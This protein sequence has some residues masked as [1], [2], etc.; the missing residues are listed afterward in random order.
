M[1]EGIRLIRIKYNNKIFDVFSDIGHNKKFLEV[2]TKDGKELFYHPDLKDLINLNLIYNTYS[3]KKYIKKKYKFKKD[4]I[5]NLKINYNNIKKI[6]NYL[7][8][9]TKVALCVTISSFLFKGK[10]DDSLPE[11]FLGAVEIKNDIEFDEYDINNVSFDEIKETL[12]NNDSIDNKYKSMIYQYISLLEE[13]LPDIDLRILNYNLKDMKVVLCPGKTLKDESAA[14]SYDANN[15]I[16]EI[17]VGYDDYTIKNILF[18]ELT[19]AMT[20]FNQTI[21]IINEKKITSQRVFKQY[22]TMNYYGESI[23]EGMTEVLANFL[24]SDCSTLAEYYKSE[25]VTFLG[26]NAT[27]APTCYKLLKL[28]QDEY[29]LYDFVS[30]N[31]SEY[32]S[33]L[34]KYDMDGIIEYLDIIKKSDNKVEVI[35]SYEF[36]EYLERLD[37]LLKQNNK[38]SKYEQ[39]NSYNFTYI[40]S[41]EI[42]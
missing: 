1:D 18:H 17:C 13:K 8:I 26:Y 38:S 7:S 39:Y 37:Y 11:I 36:N 28:T 24:T 27:I 34:K 23:D 15:N 40:L 25:E 22:E 30:G 21:S 29:T 2:R 31:I 14:G 32:A 12:N 3:D 10:T 42:K 16:L 33:V 20:T 9:L 4:K 35:N 6:S 19:H 41:K 5:N